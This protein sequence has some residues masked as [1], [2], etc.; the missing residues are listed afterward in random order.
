MGVSLVIHGA[1]DGTAATS[2]AVRD[3]VRD[4]VWQVADTHW[5]IGP[6][7][8]MVGS[9]LSPDYLADHFARALA[10]QGLGGAATLLVTRID[11]QARWRGLP[12]DGETWLR[13]GL[14]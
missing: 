2:A 1:A 3:V 12:L 6:D 13:S 7:H 10:R 11:R 5:A 8:M 14:D 9:D 4:A